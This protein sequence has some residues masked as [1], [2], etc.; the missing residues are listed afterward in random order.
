M[1]MLVVCGL[2]LS[3]A[4]PAR[5]YLAQRSEIQRLEAERA[6]VQLQVQRLHAERRRWDDPE[7]VKARARER[8]HYA[9]PGEKA[10]VAVGPNLKGPDQPPAQTD[11]DL[12]W[13]TR[14][15]RS[16]ANAAAA[17]ADAPGATPAPTPSR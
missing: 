10:Y 14:L 8:L 2:A 6:A 5:E 4:Y 17:P 3:L 11:A 13:Y 7:F 15:W 1:L 12:P 16:V 9:M